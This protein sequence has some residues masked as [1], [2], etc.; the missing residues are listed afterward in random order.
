MPSE[1]F[2][3]GGKFAFPDD[4]RTTPDTQ[5]AVLKYPNAVLQWETNR[6][7]LDGQHDN[8]TQFIA[9]DGTAVTAWRGGWSIVGPDGKELD[10]PADPEDMDGLNAHIRQFLEC[11]ETR[12][13]P[14][15]NIASMA[16]TTIVCHL[17]N[18]SFLAGAPVRWNADSHDIEGEAGKDTLSYRRDY[19]SP[20][21]L[22]SYG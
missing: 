12:D 14:R 20:W 18:A 2:N 5:I 21:T 17:I 6:R 8:G 9:A 1:V 16:K 7:P 11:V 10:K 3:Q 19:R 13:Q 22:P 15:S 4:D